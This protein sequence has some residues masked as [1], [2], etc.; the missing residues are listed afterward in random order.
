MRIDGAGAM[1]DM[2]GLLHQ[3]TESVRD[4]VDNTDKRERFIDNVL[5]ADSSDD[6]AEELTLRLI[7]YL[8]ERQDYD[9]RNASD[10]EAGNGRLR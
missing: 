8:A 9:R 10:I 6:E 4:T 7:D 5:G 3:L 1:G 2:V